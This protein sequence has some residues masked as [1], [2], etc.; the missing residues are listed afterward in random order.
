MAGLTDAHKC[1]ESFIKMSIEPI[2]DGAE[3]IIPGCMLLDSILAMA[4][5]CEKDYPN[6]LHEVN[7]VPILNVAALTIKVAEA[8]VCMKKASLPWISRKLYYN[9]AKVE[10]KALEEGAALLEYKGPGFWLD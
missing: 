7:G 10:K 3:V 8:F 4:P 6:G 2:S 9:S 5:G 1:I